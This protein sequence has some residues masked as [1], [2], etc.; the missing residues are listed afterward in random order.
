[1]AAICLAASFFTASAQQAKT[2]LPPPEPPQPKDNKVYVSVET[3]PT[4]PGGIS[5]FSKYLASSIRYPAVD[6]QNNVT[7]KVYITF[8]IERD[9][10]VTDVAAVRGP[11]ETLQAEA[12]R[13][14]QASPKWKAGVQGGKPVRVQY[15]VPIDFTLGKEKKQ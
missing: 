9:G 6:R 4:F 1:M 3:P 7:G 14:V 13:V 2:A 15:T 8:V 12:V 10:S 5:E 11:S